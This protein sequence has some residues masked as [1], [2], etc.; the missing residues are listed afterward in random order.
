[1][2]EEQEPGT[3]GGVFHD[4]RGSLSA[5]RVFLA[6]DLAQ[7]IVYIFLCTLTDRALS[8]AVLGF[9]GSTI[10]AFAAWAGGSRVAQYLGP[11]IGSIGAGIGASIKELINKRRDAKGGTEFTP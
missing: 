1:M 5:A 6:V 7:T 10:T 8:N 9:D 2:A 3:G 4:E 11:Q